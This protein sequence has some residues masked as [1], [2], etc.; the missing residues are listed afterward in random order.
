MD[1]STQ[2]EKIFFFQSP[3]QI[4]RSHGQEEIHDIEQEL[5][6]TGNKRKVQLDP[7]P[8]LNLWASRKH[9]QLGHSERTTH[10]LQPGSGKVVSMELLLV[11]LLKT[12]RYRN[13]GKNNFGLP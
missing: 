2:I 3:E 8:I 9:L 7:S 1:T 12:K 10:R 5:H 6:H 4:F 11:L 13:R